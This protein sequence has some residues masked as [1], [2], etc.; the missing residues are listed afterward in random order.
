[1]MKSHLPTYD[2][3]SNF[4]IITTE[5]PIL[6]TDLRPSEQIIAYDAILFR[7]PAGKIPEYYTLHLSRLVV[8]QEAIASEEKSIE[9]L[10]AELAEW[11]KK[12]VGIMTELSERKRAEEAFRA[13]QRAFRRRARFRAWERGWVRLVERC[14][15]ILEL[16]EGFEPVKWR[17]RA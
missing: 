1:M 16:E 14:E 12:E 10:S 2:K 13:L 7:A 5:K 3:N 6:I 17:K 8:I 9:E 15:K 4:K 11:R